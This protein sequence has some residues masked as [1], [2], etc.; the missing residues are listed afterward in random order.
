MPHLTALL[1]LLLTALL[2]GCQNAPSFPPIRTAEQVDLHRFMGDWYVLGNIPT[3]IEKSA[4]NAVE[5]Y[6][7]GSG[8]R[9]LTTFRFNKNAFNG[10]EKVYHP[11]GFVREGTNNAVWGMQFI[12]PFKAE[13][14]VLY[15][16]KDYTTT[17]IGRSKRD[18][19]WVMART[20]D[21]AE[22]DYA[23]LMR[24]VEAEGYDVSKVRR[25]PQKW[26]EELQPAGQ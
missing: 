13:Y 20:P 26:P 22:A 14:R 25:V 7:I 15:V 3:V 1:L 2:T 12:W 17:V 18:Y 4:Y 19:L 11:T 6:E 10:P 24:L 9:I 16:D 5:S 8:N 23:D 21:I